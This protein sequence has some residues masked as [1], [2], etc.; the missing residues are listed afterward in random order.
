MSLG[1]RLAYPALEAIRIPLAYPKSHA[2][3]EL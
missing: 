1:L 3:T 2:D